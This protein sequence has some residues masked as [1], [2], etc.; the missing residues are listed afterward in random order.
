MKTPYTEKPLTHAA[1]SA[2]IV[3]IA[4]LSGG[5]VANK[6]S[7]VST[8]PAESYSA[9][10][11]QASTSDVSP[12]SI[13]DDGEHL[14]EL[15]VAYEVSGDYANALDTLSQILP[16][17]SKY[18]DTIQKMA[19]IKSLYVDSA[20]QN[21]TAA[22]DAG[23]YESAIR[24]LTDACQV[25]PESTDLV[26]AYNHLV[27]N[28]KTA[29]L[30]DAEN[31]FSTSGWKAALDVLNNAPALLKEDSDIANK[32]TEYKK[33]GAIRMDALTPFQGDS[34]INWGTRKDC[35]GTEHD[36]SIW[37]YSLW[38]SFR[39]DKQY[40][41]LM[42]TFFTD[43]TG[44]GWAGTVTIIGDGVE[45]K[46]LQINGGGDPIPFEI[47]VSNVKDISF[48]SAHSGFNDIFLSDLMLIP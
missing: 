39:I 6:L 5:A 38:S 23:N 32:I 9:S 20:T 11:V 30:N 17:S 4:I 27:E 12:S 13:V 44:R 47:D 33:S 18:A 19:E 26:V 43:S 48:E 10:V 3:I 31:S 29:L 37:S 25:I 45:L 35:F 16:T 21:A 14:Y 8:E 34:L 41:T 22:F 2:G 46:S 7:M 15:A 36:N 40:S 42:G 1:I 24:I 28:C